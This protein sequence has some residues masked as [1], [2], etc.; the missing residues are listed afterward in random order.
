M[1][2]DGRKRQ[3]IKIDMFVEIIQ[4]HIKEVAN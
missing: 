1:I 2:I 4:K 3:N